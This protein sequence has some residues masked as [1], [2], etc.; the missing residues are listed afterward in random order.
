MTQTIK[1]QYQ[2]GELIFAY[3]QSFLYEAK[4]LKMKWRTESSK[5]GEVVRKPFYLIHYQG[6]KDRWNEWVDHSRMLKHNPAS[7]QMRKKLQEERR[8]T[9]AQTTKKGKLR[10][11]WRKRKAAEMSAVAIEIP[12]KLKKR[13]VRDQRFIA[14]KCLIP[15]PREPSV[16][17]IINGYK[18]AEQ[19][20]REE[21]E[22]EQQ[23]HEEVTR[24]P[25]IVDGIKQ[26]FDAALGSL[27]LYRFE[28]VQYA[29]AIKSFQ[30]K[31]MSE[32]YGAE[33]LLRLF[34]KLPEM[35]AEAGIDEEGRQLV[36]EKAEAILGYIKENRKTMILKEYE[37][38]SPHYRRMAFS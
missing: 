29:E 25:D 4:V 35:M 21:Q 30:C 3:H 11:H 7:V 1:P 23:R 34:V 8:K 2:E 12:L 14:N 38:A 6:W 31:S 28:R 9:K 26:Y 32:I 10:Q 22:L 15:L 13:L 17:Q 19:E 27:L 5:T 36:K 33:H 16:A 20:Q 18:M 37:S 24:E